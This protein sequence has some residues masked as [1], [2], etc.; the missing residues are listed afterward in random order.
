MSF[1]TCPFCSGHEAVSPEA[2]NML[3]NW[4]E[5]WLD[6]ERAHPANNELHNI[7]NVIRNTQEREAEIDPLML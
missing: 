1:I 2:V 4:I 5:E 6:R 3:A 7:L